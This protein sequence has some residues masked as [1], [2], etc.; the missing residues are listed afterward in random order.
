MRMISTFRA[1]VPARS[2]PGEGRPFSND[3]PPSLCCATSRSPYV[4][5][6]VVVTG[7]V[8]LVVEPAGVGVAA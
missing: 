2:G 3:S 8:P 1:P 6:V 4:E 5:C 7:V